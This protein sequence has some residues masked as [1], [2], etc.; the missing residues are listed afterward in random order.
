MAFKLYTSSDINLLTN[1]L[2]INI[3]E[4]QNIFIPDYIVTSSIGTN[5]WV[6][7]QLAD[8][9]NIAAN[10]RFVN[11]EEIINIAYRVLDEKEHNTNPLTSSN[12]LWLIYAELGKREFR[13]KFTEVAQYYSNDLLKQYGLAV[14]LSRL[15]QEYQIYILEELEKEINLDFQKYIWQKVKCQVKSNF[16]TVKEIVDSI[17]KQLRSSEKQSLLKTKMP[18]IHIFLDMDLTQYH[19]TVFKNLAQYCNVHYYLFYPLKQK[20]GDNKLVSNWSKLLNQLPLSLES[21]IN[22]DSNTSYSSNE[23]LLSKIQ[24]DIF[25]NSSYRNKISSADVKD[26]SLTI[27]NCYT[28]TREV[29]VLY[30]YLVKTIS[31][32]EDLG[33][34]DILVHVSD[35]DK[36]SSA[37]NAVFSSAPIKLPFNVSDKSY[38]TTDSVYNAIEALINLDD[39]YKAENIIQLLE[40]NPIRDKFKIQDIGLIRTLVNEANIRFGKNGDENLETNTVSWLYGLNRLIYGFCI[41]GD[42]AFNFEKDNGFLIDIVEGAQAFELINLHFFLS[43]IISWIDDRSVAKTAANWHIAINDLVDDFI[44]S[45]NNDEINRLKKS[46]S[47]LSDIDKYLKNELDFRV[48]K[49]FVTD[50]LMKDQQK[51]NFASYGIT[52]CSMTQMRNI[53]YKVIALLG[54][55]FNFFPRKNRTLSYDLLKDN[56]II[57]RPSTKVKDKYLFLQILMSAKEKLYLSFLGKDTKTNSLIPPS[58][59]LDDL[60]DYI[61]EGRERT[62]VEKNPLITEH[63]LH[64]FSSKYNNS[65]YPLL[66]S[67]LLNKSGKETKD[68]LIEPDSLISTNVIEINDFI[69]FFQNPIKHFY[70]NQLGIYYNESQ[71]IL[72]DSELFELDS[73]QQWSVKN[74][75]LYNQTSKLEEVRDELVRKGNLPLKNMGE[76]TLKKIEG[77]SELKKRFVEKKNGETD[78]PIQIQLDLGEQ[79]LIGNVANIYSHQFVFPCVSK[80]HSNLKYIVEYQI[81]KILLAASGFKFNCEFMS[82]DGVNDDMVNGTDFPSEDEAKNKLVQLVSYYLNGQNEILPFILEYDKAFCM[83]LFNDSDSEIDKALFSKVTASSFNYTTDY[84]KI[85]FHQGYFNDKIKKLKDNSKDILVQILNIN[86]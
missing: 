54:M 11:N 33:A 27:N 31:E 32:N 73:L 46:V 43:M 13:N 59:I 67:Y 7:I 69:N 37:I 55:N 80:K 26:G 40:Y 57:N 72:N 62:L 52:F 45:Q 9:N 60:C 63:P 77:I 35:I 58:S 25:N 51:S 86:F 50:L 47:E 61:N 78:N 39:N 23:T 12:L 79:I 56:S 49:E 76:Y 5:N 29:E 81:K 65:K 34:R 68:L 15:F 64:G 38:S 53:P 30:N 17:T 41:G 42:E 44:E 1:K 3:R 19:I 6:K 36:Y 74:I 71:E 21:A 84:L 16:L 83:K 85:E 24:N 82:I 70:N 75:F 48:V 2:A 4:A 14:K 10:L 8:K 28:P 66:Y 20:M 18:N 22:L